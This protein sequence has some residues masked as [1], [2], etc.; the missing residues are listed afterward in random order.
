MIARTPHG[1]EVFAR[2]Q[3]EGVSDHLVERWIDDPQQFRAELV[4]LVSSRR[5][6]VPSDQGE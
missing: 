1:S 6:E 5:V 3:A 2:V 4:R